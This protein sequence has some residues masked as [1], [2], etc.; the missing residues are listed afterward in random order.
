MGAEIKRPNKPR[1]LNTEAAEAERPRK[2]LREPNGKKEDLWRDICAKRILPFQT[3]FFQKNVSAFANFLCFQKIFLCL[4]FF[5][6][7]F[8]VSKLKK[9]K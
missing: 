1:F 3:S 7:Y 8:C 4:Q 5:E 6:K 2:T 9:K